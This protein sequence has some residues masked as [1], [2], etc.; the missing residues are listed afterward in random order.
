MTERQVDSV[1]KLTMTEV[2]I[3]PPELTSY[4]CGWED[5]NVETYY[6]PPGETLGEELH[7]HVL[8]INTGSA[9]TYE[10]RLDGRY[11]QGIFISGGI[12]LYPARLIMPYR[13]S[14]DISIISLSLSQELLNRNA[15][16]LLNRDRV[17]LRVIYNAKEPLLQQ[18]GLALKA[19][20]ESGSSSLVY[21]QTM[22]NAIAVHLLQQ[23]STQPHTSL[24]LD[25]GLSRYKLKRVQQYI[26]DHLDQKIPLED[27]AA[28]A[29]LSQYHFARAFKQSTGLSPHQ[30]L[31]QMRITRAQQLLKQPNMSISEV[32]IA[33]GFSNQSHF[34][35]HFKKHLGITPKQFSYR[36]Q[37]FS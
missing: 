11:H 6:L 9:Y 26:D 23:F 8:A 22:A 5:I 19:N 7:H 33:C 28:I 21:A 31:I 18:M 32:A 27:L 34:H 30:Y 3:R 14:R 1:D 16:E 13:W 15:Q 10:S 17:E 25:R 12:S 20:L 24:N 36:R 2:M 35:R 4:G 29:G 37:Y